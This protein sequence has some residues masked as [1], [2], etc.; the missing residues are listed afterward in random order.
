MKNK[1]IIY[2]DGAC[3][4]NQFKNNVGGWG[5]VLIFNDSRK[6]I[7]GSAKNTTN[8][9]MELIACIESL[10]TIKENKFPII[11]FSDSAYLINCI[12]NKWYLAWKK[13]N[14]KNSK[15]QPVENQDLWKTLFKLIENSE[16]EF[17]KVKGHNGIIENERADELARNAIKKLNESI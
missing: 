8:Q 9:R 10:K 1:I 17:K 11:I 16:I 15:K 14:W 4:G 3:S 5:A 6:E 7:F 13:N 2:C 12:N